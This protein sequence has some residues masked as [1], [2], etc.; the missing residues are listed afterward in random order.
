MIEA[1]EPNREP[2]TDD[3]RENDELL[4]V[5]SSWKEDSNMENAPSMIG[6]L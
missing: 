4:K 3:I 2:E 1:K 6:C 5:F